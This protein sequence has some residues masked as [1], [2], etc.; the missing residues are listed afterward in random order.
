LRNAAYEA[1]P[2]TDPDLSPQELKKMARMHSRKKG[3]SGSTHP[4]TKI[5]APWAGLSKEEIVETIIQLAKEGKG[6]SEI[7]RTLR[8]KY[9]V[10]SVKSIVGKSVSEVLAENNLMPQYPEDLMNLLRKSVK[11]RRHMVGNKQDLHNRRSLE[12]TESKIRR[13]ASYYKGTGVL[14][15][16]WYYKPEQAALIVKG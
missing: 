9:G 12:L 13:L 4:S 1:G 16:D 7:G 6:V 11:L 8:D 10:P 15:A 3:K 14:P 5:A 2:E